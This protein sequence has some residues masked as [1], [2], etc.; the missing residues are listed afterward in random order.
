MKGELRRQ[1]GQR[2]S[3][4]RRGKDQVG[5]GVQYPLDLAMW[6]SAVTFT[7]EIPTSKMETLKDSNEL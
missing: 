3:P 6:R 5:E 4:I 2:W 7:K 1:E